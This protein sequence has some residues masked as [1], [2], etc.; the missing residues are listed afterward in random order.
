MVISVDEVKAFGK[1]NYQFMSK[2][3]NKISIK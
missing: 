2:T 3:L 1:V